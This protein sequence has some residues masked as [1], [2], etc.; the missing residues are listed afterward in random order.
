MLRGRDH[1]GR[2]RGAGGGHGGSGL[3]AAPL[4]ADAGDLLCLGAPDGEAPLCGPA[5]V[6]CA[7]AGRM[8]LMSNRLYPCTPMHTP[9]IMQIANRKQMVV[10]SDSAPAT[11]EE[12]HTLE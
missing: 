4:A 3:C 11:P 8:L 7:S 6:N 9:G 1:G 2:V 12:L 5:P 10:E